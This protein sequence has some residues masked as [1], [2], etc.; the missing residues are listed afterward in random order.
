M[1]LQ[2]YDKEVDD[3]RGQAKTSLKKKDRK[4]AIM[5]IKKKKIQSNYCIQNK[6]KIKFELFVKIKKVFNSL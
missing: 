1:N 5:L 3:L 4:K 2:N 6:N